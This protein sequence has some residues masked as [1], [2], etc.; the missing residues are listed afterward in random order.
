MSAVGNA[1]RDFIAKAQEKYGSFYDPYEADWRS[2]CEVGEPFELDTQKVIEWKPVER[3]RNGDLSG[4]ADELHPDLREYYETFWSGGFEAECPDGP[5]S[6]LQVW[7]PEDL[8]RLKENLVGHLMAKKSIHL[9]L[10]GF[11]ACTTP[12]S[13]YILSVATDSGDVVLEKPGYRSERTVASNLAEFIAELAPAEP[14]ANPER[15]ALAELWKR[16]GNLLE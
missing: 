4:L 2:R 15:L 6:L 13:D 11:F 1:L 8:R 7:N 3:E 14:W 10:T 9:P 5:V 16:Q 12:D